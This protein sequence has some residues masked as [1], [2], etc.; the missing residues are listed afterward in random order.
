M[1]DPFKNDKTNYKQ[2][3]K[4]NMLIILMEIIS[5]FD[6]KPNIDIQTMG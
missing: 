3:I 1:R 5:T 6:I 4:N 2:Q